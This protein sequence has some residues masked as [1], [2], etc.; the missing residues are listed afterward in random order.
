MLVFGLVQLLQ[1]ALTDEE[2]IRIM[3]EKPIDGYETSPSEYGLPPTT[4]GF[5]ILNYDQDV[6]D[7]ILRILENPEKQ[8]HWPQAYRS[9][10][11][12]A[13]A[14]SDSIDLDRLINQVTKLEE[15][16]DLNNKDKMKLLQLGYPAVARHQNDQAFEF[17]KVRT[18]FEFWEDNEISRTV[19]NSHGAGSEGMIETAQGEAIRAL[20]ELQTEEAYALLQSLFADE[21]Y[22]SE[23]PLE[24]VLRGS[25]EYGGWNA[26]ASRLKAIQTEYAKRQE[27]GGVA[28]P[29]EVIEEPVIEVAPDPSVEEV[30]EDIEETKPEPATKEAPEIVTADTSNELT[31]EPSQWW[32]WLIGVVVVVG[33]LG[34]VLR[35]KS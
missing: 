28:T 1:A 8:Q 16:G 23:P 9:L 33:A 5:I 20:D 30:A 22:I 19:Y 17:L 3:D 13:A 34:L 21:R 7:G 18:E 12:I 11:R 2:I 31:E 14:D 26:S 35:R 4:S 15:S 6:I 24:M 10:R 25:L 32:L 27:L 29:A